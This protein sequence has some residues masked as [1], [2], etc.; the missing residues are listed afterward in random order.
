MINEKL[1]LDYWERKFDKP[2]GMD[3]TVLADVF[4]SSP[5]TSH[6]FTDEQK[7]LLAEILLQ[8]RKI[9]TDEEAFSAAYEICTQ[10]NM[11]YAVNTMF[12]TD[13]SG[14]IAVWRYDYRAYIKAIPD[15][16]ARRALRKI[17]G[18]LGIQVSDDDLLKIGAS[19]HLYD[20]FLKFIKEE[21]DGGVIAVTPDDHLD[22][23]DME[24]LNMYLLFDKLGLEG[25]D[26]F[27]VLAGIGCVSK[28][29]SLYSFIN[30]RGKIED[31]K[32][33][34]DRRSRGRVYPTF[35]ETATV[36]GVQR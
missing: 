7:E 34:A 14:N 12:F 15:G 11:H 32:N 13:C 9:F 25:R 17:Y 6:G 21:A 24:Y 29:I 10:V 27:S 2:D 5:T 35:Y 22:F 33:E 36:L 31:M 3:L 8:G 28:D 1:D 4:H 20:M 26:A 19:N 18:R 16:Y 23:A 30:T